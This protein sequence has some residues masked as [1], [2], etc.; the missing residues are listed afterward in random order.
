MDILIRPSIAADLPA[1]T[2]IYAENVIHGTGTF[3]LDAP[4]LDEMRDRWEDVQAH[5]LPWLVA[6]LDGDVVGYAYAH[7]FRPRPAYRYCVEDAVY[8]AP[9]ARG[10]GTGTALLTEL[11]ALC[12]KAGMRQMVAL[13]GDSDNLG[14]R[15]V[16]RKL[17]FTETGVMKSAG[18]KHGRWL[19]VVFAQLE[20]GEGDSSAPV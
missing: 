18:W 13:I 16:H 8:L 19:D 4:S 1:V 2:A 12:E 14:S 17:G 7:Q 15:G 5:G 10:H 11:I 3:E 9:A 20:L 6:E